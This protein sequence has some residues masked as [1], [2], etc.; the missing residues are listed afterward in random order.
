MYGVKVN[1]FTSVAQAE[2]YFDGVADGLRVYAW[3]RDGTMYVGTTGSTL[4]EAIH[5]L[6]ATRALAV[7][8]TAA[9]EVEAPPPAPPAGTKHYHKG[10]DD[11]KEP[12]KGK[13][14][15]K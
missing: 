7:K 4:A 5:E 3:Q 10:D 1:G 9:E 13:D 12:A 2:A 6:D 14:K 8:R 11:T 15:K